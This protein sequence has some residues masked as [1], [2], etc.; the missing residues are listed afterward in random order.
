[1]SQEESGLETGR[2]LHVSC[3]YCLSIE[4]Q[5]GQ[6]LK[7]TACK[8]KRVEID[9]VDQ[10]PNNVMAAASRQHVN[11]TVVVCSLFG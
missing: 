4:A 1:M 11:G 2:S 3:Q 6:D 7:T 10:R 5:S 8:Q 9:T